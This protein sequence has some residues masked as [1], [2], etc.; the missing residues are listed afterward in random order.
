YINDVRLRMDASLIEQ[1]E[2]LKQEF[3]SRGLGG[4]AFTRPVDTQAL[5]DFLVLFSKHEESEEGLSQLKKQLEEM[6]ELALELL[7]PMS[8]REEQIDEELRV[9][10]KTF[11]LQSYAKS[12]VSVREFVTALKQGRD[13]MQ[14]R[15]HITR[16]VQDLVDIA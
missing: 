16:V 2:T 5:R 7:G 9:D 15:L 10:R 4:L 14:G 8:M 1:I 11:A 13:P 6:K 12:I 3:A